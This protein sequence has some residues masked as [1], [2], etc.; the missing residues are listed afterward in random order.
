MVR[1]G[2]DRGTQREEGA[3]KTELKIT[4]YSNGF[5][6]DDGEFRAY[7]EPNNKQFMKELNEGFV[8]KEI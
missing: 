8:P 3:P 5:V 7:E 2:K 4:L 1:G 6:V